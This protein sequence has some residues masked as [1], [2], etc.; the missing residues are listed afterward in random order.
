[1]KIKEL[2]LKLLFGLKLKNSK[3]LNQKMMIKME[4]VIKMIKT[5]KKEKMEKVKK[6]MLVIELSQ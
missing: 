1:L 3:L 2:D 5:I 4:K 6:K